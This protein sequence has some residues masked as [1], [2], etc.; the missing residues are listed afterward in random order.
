MAVLHCHSAETGAGFAVRAGVVERRTRYRVTVPAAGATAEPAPLLP[1]GSIKIW[2][3]EV[4]L[5]AH[6]G[7]FRRTA[8]AF[9]QPPHSTRC[10]H[11]IAAWVRSAVVQF[12]HLPCWPPGL[13]ASAAVSG[14]TATLSPAVKSA[15][16]MGH[17]RIRACS[18]KQSSHRH[19]CPH[20][21]SAMVR[22]DAM[23]TTHAAVNSS[24]SS[25]VSP[26]WFDASSGDCC[27]TKWRRLDPTRR[28]SRVDG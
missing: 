20:G 10:P 27:R 21:T 15:R 23:Q 24:D 5:A 18:G 12:R 16:H 7:H 8:S 26:S 11:G 22:R 4:T 9:V 13:L 28:S 1:V 19:M 25:R 2:C 3:Q 17:H 14:G 6:S